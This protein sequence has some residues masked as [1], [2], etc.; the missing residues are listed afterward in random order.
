MVSSHV[1]SSSYVISRVLLTSK[2]GYNRTANSSN[3]DVTSQF[4]E[5]SI[6]GGNTS[7][8]SAR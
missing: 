5:S 6:S 7:P 4:S 8:G 1:T 3:V 2:I